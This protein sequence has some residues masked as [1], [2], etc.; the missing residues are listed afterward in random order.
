VPRRRTEGE[1]VPRRPI[2][3]NS[4]QGGVARPN[5]VSRSLDRAT[6]LAARGQA[7]PFGPNSDAVLELLGRVGALGPEQAE[8]LVSFWSA[9]P[10][11]ER[12]DAHAAAQET[13]ERS[14]RRSAARAAQTEA[15]RWLNE[16]SGSSDLWGSE[17]A[18]GHT[19][20]WAQIQ[21]EAFPAVLD[22]VA[23]TV[24]A[25]LLAPPAVETLLGP[26]DA[27]IG[28]PL[29]SGTGTVEPADPGM[30]RPEPGDA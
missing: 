2:Q 8:R 26:W 28:E 7:L 16:E 15:L 1:H 5:F 14:G 30:E 25:D 11:A 24:L 13:A 29:E 27:A 10:A 17:G 19:R 21:S 12:A 6:R 22:A 9:I 18:S 3:P 4:L 20:D 23:A